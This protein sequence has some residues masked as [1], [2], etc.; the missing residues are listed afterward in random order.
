MATSE[1]WAAIQKAL[2][3]QLGGDTYSKVSMLSPNEIET[4]LKDTNTKNQ[5][6]ALN[7]AQSNL[8][9]LSAPY[10]SFAAA[11]I[12][13]GNTYNQQLQSAAE[14]TGYKQAQS[15]YDAIIQKGPM[16]ELAMRPELAKVSPTF[17]GA[18]P[19][20]LDAKLTAE[21]ITDPFTKQSMIQN[22]MQYADKSMTMSLSSL[23][24]LYDSAVI[25]A[26]T[27]T[28]DK[29]KEYQKVADM[30]KEAYSATIM[31]SRDWLDSKI[32]PKSEDQKWSE[33]YQ[34]GDATVQKNTT[35]GEIR[36]VSGA[37]MGTEDLALDINE[38]FTGDKPPKTKEEA[39]VKAEEEKTVF[40]LLN[41]ASGYNQLITEIERR[42]PVTATE[43]TKESSGFLSGLFSGT[44][45]Q[46]TTTPK[47]QSRISAGMQALGNAPDYNNVLNSFF[48]NFNF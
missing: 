9:S 26:R 31:A 6:D 40:T 14:T 47:T 7:S 3:T 48:G 16:F 21:G 43:E 33:P 20:D 25:A 46:T 5:T 35:T 30:Y 45:T 22:Y 2:G 44:K 28:E 17:M 19:K 29:K 38:F 42:F 41:G 39:L 11:N 15:S 37:G 36:T 18:N 8:N 32:N 10:Q 23:G 27:A 4:V 24:Q 34:L 12:S 1:Q 13:A